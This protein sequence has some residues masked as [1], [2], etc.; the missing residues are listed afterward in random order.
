MINTQEDTTFLVIKHGLSKFMPLRIIL[1]PTGPE[2]AGICESSF[3]ME[4]STTNV[5][6]WW[7][8]TAYSILG[9]HILDGIEC[10]EYNAKDGDLIYDPLSSECPVN[11]DWEQWRNATTKYAKRNAPFKLRELI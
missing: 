9:E 7:S 11:I 10:A 2:L 4:S 5:R 8:G 6:I 3:S 1:R